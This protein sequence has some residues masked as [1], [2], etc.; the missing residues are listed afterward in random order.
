[1]STKLESHDGARRDATANPEIGN[2]V[3]RKTRD[4]STEGAHKMTEDINAPS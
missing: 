3:D 4:L 2:F 1:M